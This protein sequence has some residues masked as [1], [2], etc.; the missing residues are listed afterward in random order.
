MSMA[1]DR[2]DLSCVRLLVVVAALAASLAGSL[3]FGGRATAAQ[4]ID[5]NASAV[6]IAAN[7]KGEAVLSYRAHGRVRHV[8][9]WGAIN[10]RVPAAGMQQVKLKVDYSGGW[11]LHRTLYW[12][13]FGGRCGRYDGPLLP[14]VVAA[15]KAPDGSYWA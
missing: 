8:L 15:C 12:K 4:L 3:V 5:R 6:S 1:A 7:A 2:G 9:L 10:A 14:N 13:Q 11:H